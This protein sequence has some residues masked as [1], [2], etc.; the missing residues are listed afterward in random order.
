MNVALLGY[1]TEGKISYEYYKALGADI[2]ICDRKTDLEV[3]EG[4][5]TQLGG[6]YL[7]N[8]DRFD[9]LMR[10][11]GMP[12]EVIL[13][14]NPT[15][16]PKI[17]TQVNEFLRA[18]PTRNVIG[19]TGTKGKGTTSTL[20]AKMLEAAGRDV[21]LGGNIG[22]PVFTFLDKLSTDSWAVVELSSFQLST[23]NHSPHIAVCLMMAP[24]HLNWH[25]DMAD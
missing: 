10:T 9:V 3:P 19:I 4:V 7:D 13:E 14:K 23:V 1:D 25:K 2:T 15:V 22:I 18:C 17:T 12:P 24:E 11:A 21:H 8:L 16:G 6:N 5:A 20:T